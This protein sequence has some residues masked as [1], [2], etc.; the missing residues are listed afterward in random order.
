M[1]NTS[2]EKKEITKIQN[3]KPCLKILWLQLNF[4]CR[5]SSSQGLLKTYKVKEKNKKY[6]EEEEKNQLILM[7]NPLPVYLKATH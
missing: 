2:I 6:E 7:N 3:S 5:N 4:H 1:T